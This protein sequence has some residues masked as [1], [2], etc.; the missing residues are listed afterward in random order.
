MTKRLA[1][2]V[3]GRL[4]YCS[5]DEHNIGK[6]RC[7]HVSHAKMVNHKKNSWKERRKLFLS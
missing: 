5:A 7:N 2:T 4:T 3:D 6:G 1:M